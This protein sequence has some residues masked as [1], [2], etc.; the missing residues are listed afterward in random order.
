MIN[1]IQEHE[2]MF[3]HNR[4]FVQVHYRSYIRWSL[5]LII[6]LIITLKLYLHNYLTG[7]T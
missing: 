4:F 3:N 7:C 6:F 2:R 1:V 5:Q